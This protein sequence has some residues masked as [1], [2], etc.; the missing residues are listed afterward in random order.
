MRRHVALLAVAFACRGARSPCER[1][2]REEASCV[3]ETGVPIP[4]DEK[5]C[6]AACSSLD[7]DPQ[8]VALV[9]KQLR[10]VNSATGDTKCQ[11]V[12]TDCMHYNS[13]G[14]FGL[15]ALWQVTLERLK[16]RASNDNERR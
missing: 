7:R 11:T 1:I 14:L 12:I 8:S 6:R 13:D 16:A 9:Q 2:C 4:F 15:H 3:A 5:D 10:C